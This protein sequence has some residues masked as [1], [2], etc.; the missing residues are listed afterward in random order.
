MDSPVI[1][2]ACGDY[3]RTRLMRESQ[4]DLGGARLVYISLSPAEIFW[5][6]LKFDEFDASEMSLSAYIMGL[7]RGDTRFVAI[8]VFPSR[9]FRHSFIFV[10]RRSGILRPEDLRG[11]RV[12]CLSTT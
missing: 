7:S 1:A 12:G 11:K 2:L 3:P 6:M 8:P 9:A 4:V 10:N 5:R